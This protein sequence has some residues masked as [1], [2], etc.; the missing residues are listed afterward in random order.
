MY[1]CV[2]IVGMYGSKLGLRA[3]WPIGRIW[4]LEKAMGIVEQCR[5]AGGWWREEVSGTLGAY[6]G[7]PCGTML[8]QPVLVSAR[9]AGPA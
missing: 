6:D 1:V 5:C 8:L 3:H 9:A 4:L 2:C 7:Q